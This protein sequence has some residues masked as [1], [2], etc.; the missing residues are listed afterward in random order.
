MRLAIENERRLELAFEG[1]RW[2]DL[3]RT[4]RAMEV[5]NAVTDGA[6]N[7]LYNVSED[8]LLL[9]VPQTER[10]RNPNASQNDGYQCVQQGQQVITLSRNQLQC[11][12]FLDE[13]DRLR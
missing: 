7:K 8:D 1:H 2:F 10:D 9:P 11:F 6:G 3:L 5:M 13:I 12:H 4:G